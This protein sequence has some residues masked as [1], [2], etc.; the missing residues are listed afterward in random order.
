MLLQA[1][2]VACRFG[3]SLAGRLHQVAQQ[4][5]RRIGVGTGPMALHIGKTQVST[6]TVQP[7]TVQPSDQASGQSQGAQLRRAPLHTRAPEG[8]GQ[9]RVVKAGVVGD[10]RGI[11]DES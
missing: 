9:K 10:H 5:H 8:I 4:Q 11:A 6:E 7:V 3:S 2:Q 1:L